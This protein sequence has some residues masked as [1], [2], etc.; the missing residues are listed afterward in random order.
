MQ[1]WLLVPL[2]I[3]IGGLFVVAAYRKVR[4]QRS[5]VIAV[6]DFQLLPISFAR[7]IAH[8]LPFLEGH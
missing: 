6:V 3:F 5:F 8:Y 4:E 2:R 7:F 1:E